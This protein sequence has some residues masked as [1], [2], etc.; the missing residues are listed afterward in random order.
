MPLIRSS[1]AKISN[2]MT[3]FVS[4]PILR[5]IYGFI[6]ALAA[7]L[8]WLLIQWLA[9]RD[10]FSP[11]HFDYLLYAYMT[12]TTAVVFTG[13]GCV[14]GRREQLITGLAL[15]DSLTA[16][17][18]KRYYKN[19]LEQEFERFRRQGILMSVVQIGLDHFKNINDTWGHQAGDEVLRNLG[20][21]LLANCRKNEVA[22]RVG[23]E[24]MS[25]IVC[26]SSEDQAYQLAE[27]LRKEI[28][29]ARITWDGKLLK[30]TASFGVACSNSSDGNAWELYRNA[31]Q[32]LYRAKEE[33]R[34][35][36]CVYAPAP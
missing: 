16:L 19:R 22:A 8:G 36:T 33:G 4:L 15:T 17:Y 30:I 18:N 25:V 5:A 14:I 2:R 29:S 23:G 7:P 21:L 13:L 1:S 12:I 9:G 32:A 3:R 34:N 26:D 24:E 11:E 35:R 10:P 27:R 6:L 20:A 31:D 28:E